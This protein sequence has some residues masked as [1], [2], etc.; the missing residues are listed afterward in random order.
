M[1]LIPQLFAMLFGSGRNVVTEAAE[2]FRVN[3]EASDRRAAELQQAALQQ[4]AQEFSHPQRSA[5]DR[6]VDGMNRLPR[7][8]LALGTVSLMIAAMIDP[9]WFSA[10][11][12]GV[13]LVP[14]PLWWLL[15]AIISF[16]FGARYQVKGQEFRRSI[17]ETMARTPAVMGNLR[18]LNELDEGPEAPAPARPPASAA[19]ASTSRTTSALLATT[20]D[21]AG[22]AQPARPTADAGPTP[23]PPEPGAAPRNPGTGPNAALDAWRA[24]R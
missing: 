16:Y 9:V 6:F 11:M 17:A 19:A 22:Q 12:Q 14:E 13:A 7:P 5:F 4:F 15:G 23:A 2:V 20:P 18:A 3:A 24:G 8:L 1:A 21:G 10:R